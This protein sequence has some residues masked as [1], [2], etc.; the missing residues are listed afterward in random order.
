MSAAIGDALSKKLKRG[1]NI[2]FSLRG[3][4][5]PDEAQIREAILLAIHHKVENL[6]STVDLNRQLI[7]GTTDMVRNLGNICLKFDCFSR[8]TLEMNGNEDQVFNSN[9]CNAAFREGSQDA[10][11]ATI[12]MVPVTSSRSPGMI[13]TG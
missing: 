4:G 9:G 6:I 5:E 10:S 2:V 1:S 3:D 8:K 12:R 13:L 7:D 11:S